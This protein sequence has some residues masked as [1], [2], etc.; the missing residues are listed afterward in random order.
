MWFILS[1]SED[2]KKRYLPQ[3]AAGTATFSYG[4]SEREAGS[5]AAS[6]KTRAVRDGDSYVL[7]GTK[8][9]ITGA[10]V[11]THYTVMA[12]TDPSKGTQGISAFVVHADDPGFSDGTKERKMENG[13]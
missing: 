12:R 6:M 2:L 4:L 7:T 13:R 8:C 3:V 11:N 9:W 5:D 10:G 1:G